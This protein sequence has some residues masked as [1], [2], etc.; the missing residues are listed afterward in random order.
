MS[1]SE[2]EVALE[3]G[4]FIDDAANK[5]VEDTDG[6]FEWA[7]SWREN[8]QIFIAGANHVLAELSAELEKAQEENRV[9]RDM[10]GD[11]NKKIEKLQLALEIEEFLN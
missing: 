3:I 9:S 8:K 2:V 6:D 11:L 10:I 1:K 7:K 4:A 5:Y